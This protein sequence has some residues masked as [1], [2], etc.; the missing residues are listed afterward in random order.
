M[1][2]SSLQRR[3]PLS[4]PDPLPIGLLVV[5]AVVTMAVDPLGIPQSPWAAPVAF[6]RPLALTAHLA[7]LFFLA[8]GSLPLACGGRN[9][10]SAA[11]LPVTWTL[12]YRWGD[13]HE[14]IQPFSVTVS[15]LYP[16]PLDLHHI[17]S[18]GS[19]ALYVS[20]FMAKHL[21]LHI[22]VQEPL[23]RLPIE[24]HP[25]GLGIWERQE[26]QFIFGVD[27]VLHIFMLPLL[28]VPIL[29][30]HLNA[31]GRRHELFSHPLQ[32]LPKRHLLGGGQLWAQAG[33]LLAG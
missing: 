15:D 27:V 14:A 6:H 18:L 5:D 32:V 28:P 22:F 8:V 20:R 33:L 26:E 17:Y 30:L 24:L 1:A 4:R 11:G 13:W 2:P 19:E 10:W 7:G 9:P 3:V 12:F 21:V 23:R 25:V 16:P 29:R 31:L